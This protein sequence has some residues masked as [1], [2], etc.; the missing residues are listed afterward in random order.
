MAKFLGIEIKRANSTGILK[1]NSESGLT[2]PQQWL[3]D[4]LA[5]IFG[6][7]NDSGQQVTA[8]TAMQIAAVKD[9]VAKTADGVSNMTPT[10]AALDGDIIAYRA[11]FWADPEGSEW[12]E[13]RLRDDVS[14]WTPEGVKDV[15]IDRKSTRLNSSH[16]L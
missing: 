3:I 10:T 4:A 14:R 16:R 13:D 8:T 1:R 5:G 15:F 12:L 11:A 7:V 9:C 6:G 2:N